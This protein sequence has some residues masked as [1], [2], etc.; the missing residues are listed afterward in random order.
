MKIT[1]NSILQ[2]LQILWNSIKKNSIEHMEQ[3]IDTEF[4]LSYLRDCDHCHRDK[5]L[6]KTP[7]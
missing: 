3:I 1:K 5:P 7:T 4:V 2:I 6:L